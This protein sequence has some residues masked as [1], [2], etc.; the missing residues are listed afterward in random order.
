MLDDF[1]VVVKPEDV[2]SGVVVI[3]GPLLIAMQNDVVALRE[4]ALELDAL[5][6]VFLRHAREVVDECLLSVANVRIVLDVL[7]SHVLLDGL[8]RFALIEHQVIER[9]HGP[10]ICFELVCHRSIST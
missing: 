10:F 6:G 4:H 3:A 1:A 2:Y 9:H 8:S 7:I 5:A